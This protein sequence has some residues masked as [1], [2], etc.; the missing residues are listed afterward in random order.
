MLGLI[1]IT[2]SSCTNEHLEFEEL[3][4]E[5]NKNSMSDGGGGNEDEDHGNWVQD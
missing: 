3:A 5:I 1:A 4:E 2:M